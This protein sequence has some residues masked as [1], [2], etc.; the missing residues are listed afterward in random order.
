MTLVLKFVIYRLSITFHLICQSFDSRS[1]FE[2]LLAPSAVHVKTFMAHDS[3]NDPDSDFFNVTGSDQT[4]L[5]IRLVILPNVVLNST[6]KCCSMQRSVLQSPLL[7][8]EI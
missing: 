7:G 8:D 4:I 3:L 1:E 6:V 2:S 5:K